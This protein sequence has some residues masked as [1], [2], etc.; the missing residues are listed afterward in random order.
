[1]PVARIDGTESPNNILA[2]YAPQNVR[3]F[4]HI[5][6]IVEPNEL[7][8]SYQ[9]IYGQGYDKQHHAKQNKVQLTAD[10]AKKHLFWIDIQRLLLT[11]QQ[12]EYL[13]A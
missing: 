13:G 10:L 12:Q 9:Q 2:G 4:R 8:A 5:D 6:I 3:V 7:V 1:M 11:L